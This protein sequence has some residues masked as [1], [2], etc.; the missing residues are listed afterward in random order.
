MKIVYK[1]ILSIFFI[2]IYNFKFL[3]LITELL[4]ILYYNKEMFSDYLYNSSNKFILI[5]L[6]SRE[7]CRYIK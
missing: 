3:S 4:K 2:D 1:Q 6:Y 7:C 5:F